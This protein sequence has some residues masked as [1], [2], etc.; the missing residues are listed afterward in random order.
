MLAFIPEAHY[1]DESLNGYLLRL[2]EENFL[3]STPTLLRP[4][5]IRFKTHYSEGERSAI[6]QY[7]GLDTQQLDDMALFPAVNGS[8]AAGLFSRK[9][10]VAVCPQ[11]LQLSGYIRQAWHHQLFTACPK[12]QVLLIDQCPECESPLELSRGAVSRCGCGCDLTQATVGPADAANIFVSSMLIRHGEDRPA[13]IGLGEELGGP[14]DIDKFLLFLANLTLAVPQKKNA[15]I[16]FQRALEINQAS[17]ALAQDLPDRFRAFVLTKVQSANQLDS[18]RF[19]RHL[20]RWYH[21]LNSSFTSSA[22]EPVR[23]IASD[24]ILSHAHAPINRKMKHIGAEL[25]GMK[26]T[27]TSAEAAR[28][29]GSSPDRIVSFVKSGK[30]AGKILNGALVE[31]CLVDRAVVEALQ[32]DAKGL[33][34][35]KDLLRTLNI[36]RRVRERLLE[37]GVL[38]RVA[39]VDKPMF[40]KGEYRLIDVLRLVET[41]ADTLS[42][43]DCRTTIG[44]ED[45]SARRFSNQQASELYRLI[46]SRQINPVLQVPEVQGLA[47]FRFDLDEIVSHLRQDQSLFEM[48]ITDLTKITRWK[49]ETIKSWVDRGLLPARAEPQAGKRR[50]F[51]SVANLVTFLSTH[52]VTADAA[53]RLG[54]KSVSLT[55]ALATKGVLVKGA[56]ITSEGSHRGGL[57]SAD[58]LLNV[59]SG[60]A[61]DW[62]HDHEPEATFEA[63][64]GYSTMAQIA[65]SL[66]NEGDRPG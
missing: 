58:A 17:Y 54:S 12:H 50:V 52:I 59:A 37:S 51:I 34:S 18:G 60:R 65:D 46:F 45:I 8:M 27:F 49:H 24:V 26:S 44:I 20:G 66:F 63:P 3:G 1:V 42:E 36:S 39:E 14:G 33:I 53:K 7:H 57:V 6:G 38:S 32:H 16:G 9:A 61:P 22:Y 41:L 48:T 30:L 31:F 2:A 62:R 43:V 21:E 40:A 5:G 29:L 47:A 11:C 10:V 25:L 35:S 13:L 55:K 19:M 28:L 23:A 64:P 4:T 15:A 56:H